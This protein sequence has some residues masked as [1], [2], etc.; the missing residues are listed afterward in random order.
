M[1]EFTLAMLLMFGSCGCITLGIQTP[2]GGAEATFGNKNKWWKPDVELDVN[3][4]DIKEWAK[5]AYEDFKAGK[6]K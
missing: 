3:S 4:G 1:K 6:E 5:D 2:V